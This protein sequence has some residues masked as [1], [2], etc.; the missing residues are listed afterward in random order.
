MEAEA[1][2]E[3][4]IEIDAADEL[5][6]EIAGDEEEARSVSEPGEA[7]SAFCALRCMFANN[8]F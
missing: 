1:G 3:T 4:D 7:I 2:A 6:L 5:V 8:F